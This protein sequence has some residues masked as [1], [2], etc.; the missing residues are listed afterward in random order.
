LKI[1]GG[2]CEPCRLKNVIEFFL[3][4]TLISIQPDRA[5]VFHQIYEAH[6][7][8]SLL[9]IFFLELLHLFL[10]T[11]NLFVEF[12]FFLDSFFLYFLNL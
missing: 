10:Q 5:A 4:D 11:F 2:R 6:S 7:A 12:L 9:L 8:D 3:F 1:A